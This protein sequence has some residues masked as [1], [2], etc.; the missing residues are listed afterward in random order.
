MSRRALGASVVAAGLL[1][2]GLV[3]LLGTASA[4]ACPTWTDTKGDANMGEFPP[5]AV[6]TKSDNLDIVGVTVSTTNGALTAAVQV[7]AL[8]AMP[9]DMG[10]EY[11]VN[12]TLGGKA[13]LLYA[14]RDLA[15]TDA[16]LFNSTDDTSG[17]GSVT[18]D[19]TKDV[20]TISVP[21]AEVD[22]A[23]G[24]AAAGKVATAFHGSTWNQFQAL[25][26]LSYDQ[27]P[28]PAGTSFAIG[29]ACSAG[30]P[31]P[32]PTVSPSA[33]PSATPTASPTPAP[34]TPP[35]GTTPGP[36]AGCFDFSDP[37][38]DA[39]PVT[40]TAPAMAN[41]PD[42]DIL[43]V[44]YQTTAD[45]FTTYIKVDKLATRPAQAPGHTFYSDFTYNKLAFSIFAASYDPAAIGTA[46]NTGASSGAPLAPTAQL[47]VAGT[48]KADVVVDAKFDV[49]NS[50]VTLT[51]PRAALDKYA[52]VP[53]AD[54]TEMTLVKARSNADAGGVT[55]AGGDTT[56]TPESKLVVGSNKCFGPPAAKL[57]NAGKTTVQYTDAAA[58]A[59]K[60][61]SATG[62]ALAGK[63]VTFQVGS[64][65]ATA[66]TGSDGVARAALDPGLAAGTYSLVTSFAGDATA[67][68]VTATTPFT[69]TAE[70]TKITLTVAKSGTSRTV[71]A[72]LLDDDRRPVAG[73]TVVWFVNGK[74][75]GSAKTNAAGV[76]TLK[77]AKPT[78][79]VLAQFAGVAGKY[80]ASKSST[81]V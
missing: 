65:K 66:K 69:V 45:K 17:T 61:T 56:G 23:L 43:G 29:S 9:T 24:S 35:P 80:A 15:F 37:K 38:G 18:Y 70:V 11:A 54:G 68:K 1:A 46:R 31:A 42:L 44:A 48:Y 75:V 25:P 10:D 76:V 57:L 3:P 7:A 77:T 39:P 36:A 22:K 64:A 81:K 60:L 5:T 78:Q 27:A 26:V 14:D 13:M 72:K 79:T 47:R 40:L 73:Q 28:A 34:T 59:A 20:V 63:T 55:P 62:A 53:F 19:T 4:A 8:N 49:P 71:T 30:G 51:V 16:G 52:T 12:F 74:Q 58:L 6:A 21:A 50:M 2:G 67:G 41:D 32:T 33:T